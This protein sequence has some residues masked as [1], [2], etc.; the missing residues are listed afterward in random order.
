M[1]QY[2]SG[3]HLLAT[4]LTAAIL[5]GIWN[6]ARATEPLFPIASPGDPTRDV[7][8]FDRTLIGDEPIATPLGSG[9]AEWVDDPGDGERS[10]LVTGQQVGRT[11]D[12][13]LFVTPG[14]TLTW[15]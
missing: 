7:R 1:R 12:E 11:I 2:R 14:T 10:V 5:T 13:P 8:T 9:R 4:L 15:S 6:P 3:R